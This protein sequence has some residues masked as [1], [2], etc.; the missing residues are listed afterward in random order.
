[1]VFV[2]FYDF[3]TVPTVWYLLFSMILQLFRQCGIC[4]FLW[5]CNCSDS[6]VFVVFYDFVTVPTVWY[7]LF[8]MILQLFR[9]CGICCFLWFCNCSDSV[10]LLSTWFDLPVCDILHVPAATIRTLHQLTQLWLCTDI[11]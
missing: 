9:Q 3:V 10:V 11:T 5:F 1:V 2:V 7:L 6:V 8:S 4:C